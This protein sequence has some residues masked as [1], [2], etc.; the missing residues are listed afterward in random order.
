MGVYIRLEILPYEI[1]PWEW[2]QVYEESLLLLE[3]YPFL[4]L[5]IDEKT[6][7]VI[8]TYVDRA[9]ERV[10][11]QAGGERGW[12]VF[13]DEVTL[14]TA[15]SFQLIRNLE[16]YRER[17]ADWEGEGEQDVLA[18]LLEEHLPGRHENLLKS[19]VMVFDAKTQGHPYHLYLL[20]VAG[21]IESRFPRQAVV[22]GD[23]TK[24]QMEWA[25]TWANS[26]L[27]R[28]VDLSD[29]TKNAR[30]LERVRAL[31]RD[32]EYAL[33]AWMRLSLQERDDACGEFVRRNFGAGAV[34][35]Y[36]VRKFR[37]H[38]VSTRG[39]SSV[40]REWLI[41]GF[42]LEEACRICVLDPGGCRY[43]AAKFAECV[44][45]L[46]WHDG[47][48]HG[49]V[50]RLSTLL[51]PRREVPET[52]YSLLGR[53]I[54]T[55]A[56]VQEPLHCRLSYQEA[57]A[58]LRKEL[59]GLCDVEILA[60]ERT[61][62]DNQE[63]LQKNR[64]RDTLLQKMHSLL[65]E[66][67]QEEASSYDIDSVERLIGWGWED[68]IHP[69]V[70]D[71]LERIS[72]YVDEARREEC[73]DDLERFRAADRKKRVRMLIARQR[74]YYIHKKAW[75]YLLGLKD[76]PEHMEKVYL[77]LSVK[78]EDATLH[79]LCKALANNIP[80]LRTFILK[81]ELLH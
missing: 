10:L 6:Y 35:A 26:I 54:L 73:R 63:N 3:A 17:L 16:H 53:I 11:K 22:S 69:L 79:H 58:I 75:D 9:K 48:E 2:E 70:L 56:G 60:A 76:R 74:F 64:Q 7:K 27:P 5:L 65:D 52:V 8:W 50:T 13:G 34:S 43:D 40:L 57:L 61:G 1:D 71:K 78:A 20:A 49:D 14:Q 21:L 62:A 18:S 72:A 80:L 66:L 30:L 39:F 15:E 38:K 51:E 77:L 23:I 31:V 33:E 36:Y 28:P 24:E 4:D 29:R 44:L 37:Q 59:D 46:N 45:C 42:S 32:E 81:E 19:R 68:R 67:A 12:Q 41:L 55:M 47:P 25:A